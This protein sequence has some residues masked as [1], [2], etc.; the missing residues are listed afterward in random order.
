MKKIKVDRYF[1]LLIIIFV[2][3]TFLRLYKLGSIP[4]GPEWD[5]ASVGYNAFSIAQTGHDEWGNRFPLI[6]PAFGD[7]KNPL[8][9]YLT[10]AF[11]RFF[12]LNI[13]TTRIVNGLA[14]S[15]MILTFF[16]IG[17]LIGG[18]KIGIVTSLFIALS[19]FG[20]FFSRMAGDGIMLSCFLI[21]NSILAFILFIKKRQSRWLYFFSFSLFLSMFSYNL[22]RIIA[23]LICVAGFILLIK[24]NKDKLIIMLMPMLIGLLGLVIITT[25]FKVGVSSRLKYLSI[26]AQEKGVVLEVNSLRHQDKNT[27]ISKILHNKIVL[28]GLIL[29]RNYL[30]HFSTDFLVNFKDYGIVSESHYP[31]LLLIQLPFF[32]LGLVYLVKRGKKLGP[33]RKIYILLIILLLIAPLPSA[34]TEGAPSGKRSL[35]NHGLTELITAL[36]F[37]QSINMLK[38]KA[39]IAVISVIYAIG[40]L[41]FFRFF[42][43]IYPAHYGYIY[44]QREAVVG[45]QIQKNYREADYFILSRKID[46]VPYIF[47]LFYLQYPPKKF[48][49]TKRYRLI[50]DWFYVD[51]FD[52]FL[53]YDEIN[54]DVFRQNMLIGKK[55]VVFADG[56]EKQKI[57]NLLET[58]IPISEKTRQNLPL[59]SHQKTELYMF[60]FIYEKAI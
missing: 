31:P 1:L 58:N 22:A 36:G 45:Q 6:F 38:N 4:P 14:G 13:V 33:E 19:P 47:P 11:V 50:D 56:E 32:Y 17:K 52:K 16:L 7:Y 5:E 15:L 23:P 9:I 46:G 24:Q 2:I 51:R 30:S 60:R 53:F 37:F 57:Q 28:T 55:L 8:Y 39:A 42:F 35:A 21:S 27:L 43:I 59:Y 18:R 26:L 34:I 48:I 29:S 3:G 20:L 40:V 49:E 54:L 41:S 12:G 44:A 10:A 25:Q